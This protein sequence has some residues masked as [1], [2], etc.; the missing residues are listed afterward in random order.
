[1][2]WD[3]WDVPRD[4]RSR[5]ARVKESAAHHVPQ[6][7]RF[8][9]AQHAGHRFLDA[10]REH[11]RSEGRHAG[12]VSLDLVAVD[13]HRL[14]GSDVEQLGGELPPE[15]RRVASRLLVA[16]ATA[17]VSPGPSTLACAPSKRRLITAMAGRPAPP[18]AASAAPALHTSPTSGV[19]RMRV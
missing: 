3:A 9:S 18:W 7:H 17:A 15:A 19:I 16:A 12:G 14:A 2:T 13:E 10:L 11:M 6:A 1:M 4:G 5:S 8:A